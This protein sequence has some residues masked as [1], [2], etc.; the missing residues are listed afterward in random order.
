MHKPFFLFFIS[1]LLCSCS[2]KTDFHSLLEADKKDFLV[3]KEE[4]KTDVSPYFSSSFTV[5]K[6]AEGFFVRYQISKAVK[7][8]HSVRI[9]LSVEEEFYYFGY[10]KED[11]TLVKERTEK[12]ESKH[13]YFGIAINFV[14]EVMVHE[15]K[16]SFHSDEASFLY[17]L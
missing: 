13:Q 1:A 3:S 10:D 14:S 4:I 11:Y 12:D 6:G 8:Y 2:A 9:L 7:D 16:V 15:M 5:T 17:Q